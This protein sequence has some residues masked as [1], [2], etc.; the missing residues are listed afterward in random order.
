MPMQQVYE[1]LR[2]AFLIHV[3]DSL[4]FK[5]RRFLATAIIASPFLFSACM[6]SKLYAKHNYSENVSS[7]L[8]SSDS[9]QLV[10]MTFDYHYIFAAD[11]T[12][13]A[14]LRSP[15]HR[16]AL[17]R[18]GTLHVSSNGEAQVNLG[19]M[20]N[21]RDL[22]PEDVL[23]AKQMGYLQNAKNEWS[24]SLTLKGT[25]YDASG[26]AA[27]ESVKLNRSY[28]VSVSAEDSPAAKTRKAILTPITVAADGALAI[29]AIPLIA[30]ATLFISASCA[31][32]SNCG[33]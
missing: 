32:R 18:F 24:Q 11:P 17:A 8:I 20:L 26:I 2:S 9:S 13:I 10:V 16:Y 12:V 14:L 33:K 7:I 31:G 1:R 29:G 25:R 23:W 4:N 6:T 15:I 21:G 27:G 30:V 22:A 19:L 5:Q 28:S 3:N